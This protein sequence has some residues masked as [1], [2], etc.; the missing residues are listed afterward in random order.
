MALGESAVTG[1]V[2]FESAGLS[3][4][5]QGETWPKALSAKGAQMQ[6]SARSVPRIEIIDL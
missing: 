3:A 6:R 5:K 4:A 2:A 1:L